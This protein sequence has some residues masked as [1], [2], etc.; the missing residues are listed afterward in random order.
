MKCRQ[1]GREVAPGKAKR[2]ALARRGAPRGAEK[3]L[4]Q[5]G[6]HLRA[7]REKGAAAGG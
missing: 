3:G 7:G 5:H 4:H 6:V 2:M 1:C